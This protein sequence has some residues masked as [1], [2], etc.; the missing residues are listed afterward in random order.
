MTRLAITLAGRS[1]VAT[2]ALPRI[3]E[4]AR[5]A[6]QLGVDQ[7]GVPDHVVLGHELGGYP[8][9][10][11]PEEADS[12]Y[13]EP[14]TLLAAV[15]AVTSRIELAPSA[16]IVPLRPAALL[17]KAAATLDVLS[18]GRLVLGAGVGWN[19]D[20]FAAV[21]VPF[22]GRGAR[23]DDT[24]RAC[25]ALWRDAPASFTSQTVS[26]ENIHLAPRP[27]RADSIRIWVAGVNAD[28]VAARVADYADGWIPP[29]S[30]SA[31]EVAD[32]VARIRDARQRAGLDPDAFDV[33][34]AL[35]LRDGNVERS[36]EEHAPAFAEAGVTML[37][38]SVGSLAASPDDVPQLLD[39]IT[40]R[41]AD[42]R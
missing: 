25:R 32:G 6:E 29:P 19:E 20:E 15:A 27:L 13:P 12:P 1:L 41:F 23:M 10:T 16:L 42:Y 18:A 8:H 24:L 39:R 26:F 35:P 36:L 4:L 21:G 3:P 7:L 14:L 2:A 31:A 11:F 9:G 17:A 40:K 37:Q 33:K 34:I 28:K 38:V 22:A 30:H 5:I